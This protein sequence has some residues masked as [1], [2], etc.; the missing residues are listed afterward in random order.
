MSERAVLLAP[1][2]EAARRAA[3]V[4]RARQW[5]GTPHICAGDI[6]G[7]GVDCGMLIARVFIDLGLVAPFDPRPYPA[8]WMM[9]ADAEKYLGFVGELC[10]AVETPKPGDIA[11]FVFGK[12]YSHGGIISGVDPMKM[13]HAWAP[14][15]RVVEED[16]SHNADLTR[17]HRK[18]RFYSLWTPGE[19]SARS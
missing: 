8:D 4:A 7:V 5:I 14:R 16:L 15:G 1:E 17:P 6:L 19:G 12:C 2:T 9:H 3:V 13:I 18:M 11:L 10:A